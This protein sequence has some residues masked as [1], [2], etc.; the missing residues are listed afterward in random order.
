MKE[1]GNK[2]YEYVKENFLWSKIAD[3]FIQILNTNE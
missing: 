1:I 2:G 3:D